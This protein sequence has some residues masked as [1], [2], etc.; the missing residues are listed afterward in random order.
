MVT[1]R[2]NGLVSTLEGSTGGNNVGCIYLFDRNN[3]NLLLY[4]EGVGHGHLF[5]LATGDLVQGPNRFSDKAAIDG[6]NVLVSTLK[7][8]TR[9]GNLG[10]TYLLGAINGKLL[11][12]LNNPTPMAGD[13][14]GSLFSVTGKLNPTFNQATGLNGE[15]FRTTPTS[16]PA[17]RTLILVAIGLAGL[18]VLNRLRYHRRRCKPKTLWSTTLD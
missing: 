5:G 12:V 7:Y 8:G 4:G 17:P 3:G 14:V 15:T 10:Q 16:V 1:K 13:L 18:V 2:S 9:R 11:Q 6:N